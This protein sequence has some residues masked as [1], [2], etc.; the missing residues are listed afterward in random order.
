MSANGISRS[1]LYAVVI[2]SPL[3]MGSNR[4]VFWIMNAALAA[5][6]LLS[7][8][9][10]EWRGRDHSEISWRMPLAV[11]CAL[12]VSLLWM[13]VQSIGTMPAALAHPVWAQA[14]QILPVESAIS[15]APRLTL[16]AI[17][18]AAPLALFIAAYRR[19]TRRRDVQVMLHL[20]LGV[21]CV[22]AA[23]GILVEAGDLRTVGIAAKEAYLGW[24]T[25]TFV[26]RNTAACFLG[27]G[28]AVALAL[29]FDWSAE[30]RASRK[31]VRAN[32]HVW[33]GSRSVL[34]ALAAVFLWV[35]VLLTGSRG[36]TIA[37]ILGAGAVVL[38]GLARRAAT[39]RSRVLWIVPLGLALALAAIALLRRSD[40]AVDSNI[41]RL[42]LY[43][44]SLDAIF[45]RPLL[46]HG[47]GAF[48]MVQPL[49]HSATSPS[50][51]IWNH[52]HSGVLE[53][54]VGNGL[55]AALVVIVTYIL[56][57]LH[58]VNAALRDHGS[59]PAVLAGLGAMTVAG[60]HAL[61]DFSLETQAVA[62][63]V[64]ILA[65]LGSGQASSH[66][67]TRKTGLEGVGRERL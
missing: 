57:V 46:G 8:A 61:F 33:L 17:A 59:R 7:F 9:A 44:E 24:L 63:Y 50:H 12:A 23:F 20:M 41:S 4:P 35:A 60:T 11:A 38:P 13:A 40:D 26:N 54:A 64:A 52:A 36:G 39:W 51:F 21:A 10:A 47:S 6:C 37:T 14:A 65:G 66:D 22:V 58:L 18:W 25:G 27:V 1:C 19:G 2:A 28:L 5:T 56:L 62:L 15:I 48:E 67:L 43:R 30:S 16:T 53:L 29:A 31:S 3:L 32:F 55:P 34:F 49:Y 42:S 45:S